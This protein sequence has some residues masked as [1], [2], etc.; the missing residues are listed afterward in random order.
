MSIPGV[1]NPQATALSAQYGVIV[2]T[3]GQMSPTQATQLSQQLGDFGVTVPSD[4]QNGIN[5]INGLLPATQSTIQAIKAGNGLAAITD[6]TPLICAGLAATGVGTVAVAAL[7]GGIA[8]F[9][10][11]ASALGLNQQPPP[12]ETCVWSAGNICNNRA[13]PW[14]PQDPSWVTIEALTASAN[15]NG[16]PGL[17]RLGSNNQQF[18]GDALGMWWGAM[19]AELYALGDRS[20][21]AMNW[22]TQQ[23]ESGNDLDT[24]V[25]YQLRNV[26]QWSAL[27]VTGKKF[28]MAF[29]VAWARMSETFLNGYS[30][31]D[32]S[33]FVT[34][35]IT[36]WNTIHPP[37]RTIVFDGTGGTFLDNVI[38]GGGWTAVDGTS[39]VPQR[40]APTI[41]VNI[42]LEF[43]DSGIIG[44]GFAGEGVPISFKPST[45]SGMSTTKKAALAV[46]GT[47]VVGAVGAAIYGY[48]TGQGV[49]YLFGLAADAVTGAVFAGELAAE[50]ASGGKT[51]I[52]S[53][54]FPRSRFTP[55]KAKRWALAHG[56]R[57][58]K[59]DITENYVRIRQQPPSRFS[60]FR[61]VPLGSSGV[62]AVVGR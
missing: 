25:A 50:E 32:P 43:V 59:T 52:Q 22:A 33:A 42:P 3:Y 16:I 28:C 40:L 5:A 1:A 62:K 48:V 18:W 20:I 15:A 4:V 7:A 8:A 37:S 58:S 53:L 17:S 19:G 57:A 27:G 47:V 51:H 38:S 24:L 60:T 29:D 6:A 49:G 31:P 35:F 36:A 23:Q 46:G 26:D 11:I 13:R 12:L 45:T 55:S 21:C 9:S 61:T 54:L 44:P 30:A 14:G 41:P 39:P 10:A 56:Y 34:A 2:P